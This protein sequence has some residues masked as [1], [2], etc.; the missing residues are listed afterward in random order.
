MP[1]GEPKQ[2]GPPLSKRRCHQLA[3]T[4]NNRISN[5][6][7]RLCQLCEDS[8]FLLE[9]DAPLA[10]GLSADKWVATMGELRLRIYVSDRGYVVTTT[11]RAGDVERMA[12]E[13]HDS[14]RVQ[15][16]S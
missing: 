1:A 16:L 13:A 5:L 9:L 11:G 7:V 4:R 3:V 14:L 15:G 10:A 12:R 6:F 8:G 2:G